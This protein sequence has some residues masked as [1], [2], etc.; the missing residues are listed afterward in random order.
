MLTAYFAP[1]ALTVIVLGIQRI[2]K[3]G[4][5]KP[6]LDISDDPAKDKNTIDLSDRKQS[7][8]KTED[9][10]GDKVG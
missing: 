2:F 1:L 8:R 3:L 4:R 9:P 5:N 7:E 6:E 10:F